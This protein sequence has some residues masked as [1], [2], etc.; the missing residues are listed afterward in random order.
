MM[1]HEGTYGFFT[2]LARRMDPIC[3]CGLVILILAAVGN[4]PAADTPPRTAATVAAGEK[5]A[6]TEPAAEG[7]NAGEHP[8]VRRP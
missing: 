8:L 2:G 3:C 6:N 5:P 7:E 1:Q 4:L